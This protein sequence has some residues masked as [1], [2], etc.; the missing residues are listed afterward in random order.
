MNFSGHDTFHCRLFWLKKGFD[1]L[2]GGEKFKDDSGVEMGVGRNMVNSIRFWMKSFDV[3]DVP[4]PKSFIVIMFLLM[5]LG[6]KYIYPR[7]VNS[8]V[9][10]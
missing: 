7:N 6:F 1:Y 5:C 8:N 2:Q 4:E 9:S 3:I 10:L